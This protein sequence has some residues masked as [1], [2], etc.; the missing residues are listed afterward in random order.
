MRSNFITAANVYNCDNFFTSLISKESLISLKLPLRSLTIKSI[1][2]FHDTLNEPLQGI[3]GNKGTGT[4]IF[5][6]RDIFKL[7]SGNKGTLE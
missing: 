4:F 3:L 1:D 6:N 7:F 2:T 5:G